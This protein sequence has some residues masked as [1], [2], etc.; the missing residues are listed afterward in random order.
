MDCAVRIEITLGVTSA[1]R[2]KSI[3]VGLKL[4]RSI[5]MTEAD[6]FPT[7]TESI[8]SKSYTR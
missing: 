6:A 7:W 5:C 8:A 3:V 1:E 2:M 4:A